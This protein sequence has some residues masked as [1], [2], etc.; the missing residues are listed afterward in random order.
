MRVVLDTNVVVS[1]LIWSGV[2]FTL[3]QA[4]IDGDVSIFTSPALLMEL[5][6]VL[7]RPHLASRLHR[8]RSSVQQAL[9]LYAELATSVAPVSIPRVVPD[10]PDDP[11]DDHVIAAAVAAKADLIVS[12]DRHL[13][14]LGT[15]AAIRIVTPSEALSVIAA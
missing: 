12:G 9:V 11:D 8:H 4:A 1:A 7:Q 13:L 14:T 6:D 3:L 15:H 5:H 2:P 10:D